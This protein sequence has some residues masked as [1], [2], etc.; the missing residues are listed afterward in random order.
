MELTQ[1]APRVV[2]LGPQRFEPNLASTLNS[3]GC[4]GPLAVVTAGWQ[5][6]EDEV[7]ELTAHVGREV[8]N[9][10][11][12]RRA[13]EVTSNDPALAQAL[14]EKQE[15]LHRLQELYRIRLAPALQAAR[16][17]LL[18]PGRDE[19]LEQHRGAAIRAVRTL[20]RQHV[21]RARKIHEAFDAEWSPADR[22]AVRGH[23]GEILRLLRHSS[24]LAIAGGHVAVLLNRLRL[25]DP[26]TLAGD[27]PLVA[28]SAGAMVLS[29][30]IVLFHDSPPQGPGDA[31][32]LDRGL[33][34]CAGIIPLPSAR[35]RLR[36][37]DPLRVALFCRRFAPSLCVALE[38]GTR[39]DWDDGRWKSRD[40]ALAMGRR[41]SLRKVV[42]A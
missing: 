25:F 38:T 20:D 3:L 23:R 28:W 14:R 31:E 21:V 12:Y 19:L 33:A 29:E 34:A 13:E 15:R 40:G 36:L 5:E 11:L 16:T 35:Q 6:R 42:G 24:A 9:L 4:D 2:M 10:A 41:G 32:V 37:D 17:V 8:V 7:D 30:R 39:L 1:A 27:L 26:I 22:P 18:R